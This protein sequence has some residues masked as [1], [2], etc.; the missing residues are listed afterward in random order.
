MILYAIKIV[1][2]FNE[3]NV[4]TKYIF[5]NAGLFNMRKNGIS[6]QLV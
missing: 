2:S 3:M 6:L 1:L 4:S 5:K